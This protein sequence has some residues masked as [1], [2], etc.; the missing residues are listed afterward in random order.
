MK[1]VL[2]GRIYIGTVGKKNNK[3]TTS[4]TSFQ[5]TLDICAYENP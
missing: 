2:H 1:K 3:K 4:H 5:F